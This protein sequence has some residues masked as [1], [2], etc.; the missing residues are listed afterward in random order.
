MA[1]ESTRTTATYILAA[2]LA[3]LAG[4]LVY[5][6]VSLKQVVNALPPVVEGLQDVSGE[7][8]PVLERVDLILETT[9]PSIMAE[10]AGIRE[11]VEGLQAQLPDVLDEVAALREGTVPDVLAEVELIRTTI[12][13]ILERVASI[14]QQLPSILAE[15]EAVRGEVPGIV[16]QVEGIQTQIPAILAEVEAVRIAIPEYMEDA[17]ALTEKVRQAGKEASEGAVQGFFSGII[18]APVNMVSGLGSTM[19]AGQEFSEEGRA[20]FEDKL[21][22]ILADPRKG[23]SLKWRNHKD[24]LDLELEVTRVRGKT[25]ERVVSLSLHA[26]KGNRKADEVKIVSREQAD[27]SWDTARDG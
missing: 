4:A 16:A 26:L 13:S 6:A 14:Q 10:V 25:G 9:V 24:T 22:Q 1:S 21:S 11:Q 18:K 5:F 23:A 17:D 27:G 8:P 7:I 3:L 15:V 2:A 20:V 12:P 19:I